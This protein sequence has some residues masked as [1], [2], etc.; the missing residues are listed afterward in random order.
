MVPW[1]SQK[2]LALVLEGGLVRGLLLESVSEKRQA[3]PLLVPLKF[4][5]EPFDTS[6]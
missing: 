5:C 6:G 4:H 1:I 2:L 3:R